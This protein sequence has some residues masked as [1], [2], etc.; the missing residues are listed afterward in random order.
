[1]NSCSCPLPSTSMREQT[2]F[3]LL[4]VGANKVSTDSTVQ[5]RKQLGRRMTPTKLSAAESGAGVCASSTYYQHAFIKYNTTLWYRQQ[6][7]H[8]C[9]HWY[10]CHH[11]KT[12]YRLQFICIFSIHFRKLFHQ[13]HFSYILCVQMRGYAAGRDAVLHAQNQA[14]PHS[15]RVSPAR[16]R[17]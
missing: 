11:R 13:K 17:Q 9:V 3:I 10:C 12:Q 1:M 15:L 6:G 14:S 8:C 7:V 4:L 2:F 16:S 5:K